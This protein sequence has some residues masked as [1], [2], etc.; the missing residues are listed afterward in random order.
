MEGLLHHRCVASTLISDSFKDADAHYGTLFYAEWKPNH[1]DRTHRYLIEVSGENVYVGYFP[2]DGRKPKL[3]GIHHKKQEIVKFLHKTHAELQL[4]ELTL[5]TE[6]NIPNIEFEYSSERTRNGGFTETRTYISHK[7][8]EFYTRSVYGTFVPLQ[9]CVFTPAPTTTAPQGENPNKDDIDLVE[10]FEVLVETIPVT[11]SGTWND[12]EVDSTG[13]NMGNPKHPWYA[14]QGAT[15]YIQLVEG[16][17]FCYPDGSLRFL[18]SVD[19]QTMFRDFTDLQVVQGD[20]VAYDVELP[21]PQKRDLK[22]FEGIN[23]DRHE[24]RADKECLLRYEE[25]HFVVDDCVLTITHPEHGET[26]YEAMKGE[27]LALLPGTSRPFQKAEGR[28]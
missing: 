6:L 5:L 9:E 27:M 4:P 7:Q 22:P 25:K 10:A 17:M 1:S 24:I 23:I 18:T 21:D 8:G 16:K 28:D 15:G 19:E 3:Y 11:R 13:F 20:L 12:T 2:Y 14:F 26:K